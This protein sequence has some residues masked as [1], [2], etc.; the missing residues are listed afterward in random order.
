MAATSPAPR[1]AAYRSRKPRAL[2]PANRWRQHVSLEH[3]SA[4]VSWFP[5]AGNI[6]TGPAARRCGRAAREYSI[7]SLTSTA[8]GRWRHAHAWRALRLLMICWRGRAGL[9]DG[10]TAQTRPGRPILDDAAGLSALITPHRLHAVQV[11]AAPSGLAWFLRICLDVAM[12]VSRRRA[13]RARGCVPARESP[14]GGATSSST[15]HA[16]AVGDRCAAR[17][18]APSGR[19]ARVRRGRSGSLFCPP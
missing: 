14:S 16:V 6:C 11:R 12:P 18:R 9:V 13:R 4:V 7:S 15:R 5:G 10:V 3:R 8:L 2:G 19:R 1:R 17:A